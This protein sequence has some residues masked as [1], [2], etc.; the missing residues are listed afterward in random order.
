MAV[1][2]PFRDQADTLNQSFNQLPEGFRALFSDTG[3]FLSPIGYLSSQIYYLMLPMMLSIMAIGLGSSLLAREERDGTLELLL[4]RPVSRGKL[5]LAKMLCGLKIMLIAGL[6]AAVVAVPLAKAINFGVSM[7]NVALATAVALLLSIL[8]GTI[9]FTLTAL[10]RSARAASIGIAGL[11]AFGGYV[12]TSLSGTVTWL[13]W[14]AKLMPYHYYRPSE[15]LQGNPNWWG[16]IGLAVTVIILAVVAWL[17]FRH[18]DIG[19]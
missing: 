18:R 1:Y 6:A 16:I 9:A 3:D 10:G 19:N 13:S 7:R 12:I 8:F 2:P 4:S 5:L 11:I 17:G 14:P 15:I